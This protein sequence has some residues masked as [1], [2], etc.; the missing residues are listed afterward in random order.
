MSQPASPVKSMRHITA[1]ALCL[2][3]LARAA[4]GQALYT[5]T[6][7]GDLG[8]GNSYG[9]GI[10]NAGTVVGYSTLVGTIDAQYLSF[11]GSN[12][13]QGYT[14]LI[15][16]FSYSN[17]VMTDL[18]TAGG[19]AS[20]AQAINN[21][22][23]IT[24]WLITAAG[25][26]HPFSYSN[27]VMT[28]LGLQTSYNFQ[29]QFD[30]IN[31]VGGAAGSDQNFHAFVYVNGVGTS[32]ATLGGPRGYATGINDSGIVVGW[33]DAND[34]NPAQSHAFSYNIG[35]GVM[36]DL[37]TLNGSTFS[38]ADAINQAGVAAG[39][40]IDGPNGYNH[41]VLFSNGNVTDLG[42][43]GLEYPYSIANA[44]NNA[45]VVVGFCSMGGEV[46]S[47]Y[48]VG[49]QGELAFIYNNGVMTDLNTVVNLPNTTLA[50]AMAINDLGQI[51][52]NDDT[53]RAFL[54][55]P[56]PGAAPGIATQPAP[57]T[58]VSGSGATFSV[59]GSGVSLS[60]QWSL[61]GAALSDGVRPDG[62]VVSGSLTSSLSLSNVQSDENNAS[63]TVTVAN[64]L[65][66]APSSPATLTVLGY[67]PVITAQPADQVVLFGGSAAFS[68]ATSD[69]GDTFQ[70]Q[71]NGVNIA[72]AT[73]PSLTLN[74]VGLA[75]TGHYDVVLTAAGGVG[76]NT[77][78]VATLYINDPLAS[79]LNWTATSPN[80]VFQ[81]GRLEIVSNQAS[82]S[83]QA[84]PSLGANGGPFVGGYTTTLVGPSTSD[85]SAQVDVHGSAIS[86]APTQGYYANL[87][88]L[89]LEG[90]SSYNNGVIFG[91]SYNMNGQNGVPPLGDV[92]TT[93]WGS[94]PYL[95][96][97]TPE[98]DYTFRVAYTSATHQIATS[99]STDGGATWTVE[100][101]VDV[102]QPANY[103]QGW[104]FT[105]GPGS[106]FGIALAG[107]TSGDVNSGDAYFTNFT[108]SG[109][110][111]GQWTA[112]TAYIT[113][114]PSPVSVVS[115][116]TATFSASAVGG[117]TLQYQWYLNGVALSD[118]T[119]ISGSETATLSLSD[120]GASEAGSYT[121]IVTNGFSS[122]Q[123]SATLSVSVPQVASI[124][125]AN[126]NAGGGDQTLTV[127]GS[128]FNAGD[129]VVW[130][131]GT[132][133]ETTF[134]SG[135][136]LTA[137]VPAADLA[138]GEAIDTELISVQSAGGDLSNAQTLSI[139]SAAV[140]QVQ[141]S[142]APAGGSTTA[143]TA[144]TAAG[145]AG[146]T[147]TLQNNTAGA[148]P[149]AV[150]VATY[151]SNPAPVAPAIDVGGE[152]VDL[153]VTSVTAS[154]TA[155][156][157][158][159]YPSTVTGSN[160]D[161]L[162]LLYFDGANWDPVLS[163]GGAV[164]TKV[165]TP[166]LDGT[167]SGGRFTVVFDSTSTPAIT[168][169]SGTVITPSIV[170][171]PPV[172]VSV[173]PS[174]A[175]LT[176]S[177]KM[178]PVSL[179]VVAT[180]PF[181][182]NPFSHILS[183]ASN[184]PPTGGTVEWQVTGALTL[185]LLAARNDSGTGRI[186]TI[187]VVTGDSAGNQ[188]T[189]Q[190]E[191]IVPKDKDALSDPPQIVTQ[192]QGQT[193]NAGASV[194]FSVATAT[195]LPVTYQWLFDGV[196]I[197]GATGTMLNLPD[198]TLANAG[199]YTVAATNINGTTTS[200]KAKLTVNAPPVFTTEPQSVTA[201]AGTKVVLTAVATG[202]PKPKYQW[203]RNGVTLSGGKSGTLTLN[204][205]RAKNAGTY[206]VTAT[207]TFGSATSTP[208]VL[209]VVPAP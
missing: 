61:N 52:A 101:S 156:A 179:A 209:T 106:L 47:G 176:Q 178:M 35:T 29:T 124:S 161:N 92:T 70:W 87:Q 90:A 66:S 67:S 84:M 138:T 80:G 150:S 73:Q 7:L 135:G 8:G 58:A 149:A 55:T 25:S 203:F 130:T 40:A 77:S 114:A 41:A 17:G 141:A 164:P 146:V 167:V 155:T 122:D 173:T 129:T 21:A 121:V 159:Y 4:L 91:Y 31:N 208:A 198:V 177:N 82:A 193:V 26:Y 68:V 190:T 86:V 51:V 136:V 42:T 59:T 33:S 197:P 111:L 123:A 148:P 182:P 189:A 139:V 85:W 94:G 202:G 108:Y 170:T 181:Y 39:F 56:I 126:V 191:V 37:G 180:D 113:S 10:N 79:G 105:V 32:L 65:G 115:G 60:Y 23:T 50:Q 125:P 127:N 100:A 64:P 96:L 132:P 204:K 160:A 88:V 143:S 53:G 97:P 109:L 199:D 5:A 192:P 30:C 98:T 104:G 11:P 95:N 54:L 117:G 71:H 27:G 112:T 152:Y 99:Y 93:I 19:M 2:S 131:D 118:G 38:T 171:I 69:V 185:N 120:V 165:E 196:N 166:N 1:I 83:F 49:V 89:E 144:P 187:T 78:S 168:E 158:F 22:G 134:V 81:N 195:A 45:G 147:A 133:L 57:Q 157:Y 107:I 72:G 20:S 183:V 75:D 128:N 119:A 172:I 6:D 163:S 205:V 145:S 188:A 13:P 153:Q 44:I 162:Q 169:L 175:Y 140:T 28:D 186:Y 201:A 12:V 76:T 43:L 174:P 36:T 18:G 62:S 102:T 137:F 14:S 154:D 194:T 3:G 184:E 151:S 116:G 103:G 63:L 207:N 46:G 110:V 206:T 142:V 24:G 34:S 9:M 16:A 200:H 74:G 48:P 15:H